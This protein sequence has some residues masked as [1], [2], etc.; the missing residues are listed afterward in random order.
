M[1]KIPLLSQIA[2]LLGVALFFSRATA[3][4]VP[5]LSPAPT[6]EN[7]PVAVTTAW[8]ID[9]IHPTGNA[10][11][12]VVLE[13]RKGYHIMADKSQLGEVQDFKPFPTRVW[14]SE[15]TEGVLSEPPFYPRARLFEVDFVD[16]P[17]MSFEGRAVI[18]LPLQLSQTASSA[19][20]FVKV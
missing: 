18:Y 20:V 19:S 9:R 5:L 7:D 2:F 1:R 16:A 11:L 8:S 17:I 14:V 12:A 6:E 15:A 3:Q 13:I 10:V 4:D